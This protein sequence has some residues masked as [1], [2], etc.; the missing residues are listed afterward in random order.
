MFGIKVED[1]NKMSKEEVFEQLKKHLDV[2]DEMGGAMYWN[3][4]NDECCEIANRC[5]ALGI[6]RSEIASLLGEGNYRL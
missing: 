6:D 2:R 3:I 5:L 1:L 4:L